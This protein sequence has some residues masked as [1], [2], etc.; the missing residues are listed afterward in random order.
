VLENIGYGPE[1]A[2][3][4][5][6]WA[7]AADAGPGRV[8]RVDGGVVSVL[9]EHGL[10]RI[11]LGGGLLGEVAVHPASRP[12]PG[13]W[14][15]VREWC[16]HRLTLEAVLPRHT[17][18]TWP[19]P[20]ST[21]G[22]VLCANADVVAVVL[23]DRTRPAERR[24]LLAMAH[25]SGAR[26]WVVTPGDTAETLRGLVDGHLTLALVGTA[27][28]HRLTDVLVGAD[29]IG[30]SECGRG[31]VVLPGGGAVIDTPD[32]RRLRRAHGPRL[33]EVR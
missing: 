18:V 4:F 5:A 25:D 7:S 1:V 14:V 29:V 17:T 21:E 11:G 2:A 19:A 6:P 28:H 3:G 12:C 9:T 13:D 31:L 30:T 16:D 27:E 22:E 26:T 20:A 33:P 32:V 10:R 8:A 23:T 24:R 15:V